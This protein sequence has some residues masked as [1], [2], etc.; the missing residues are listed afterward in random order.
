MNYTTFTKYKLDFIA[1]LFKFVRLKRRN[2]KRTLI[3]TFDA[4]KATQSIIIYG[5]IKT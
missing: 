2:Y 4:I 5:I 3:T 1:I